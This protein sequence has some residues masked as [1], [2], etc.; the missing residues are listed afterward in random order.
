M[1]H[2]AMRVSNAKLLA[3]CG[4]THGDGEVRVLDNFYVWTGRADYGSPEIQRILT[5][6]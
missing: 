3:R 5:I 2:G 6:A 4:H 1:R